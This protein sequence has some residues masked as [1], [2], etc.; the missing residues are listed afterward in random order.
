MGRV[1]RRVLS[2]MSPVFWLIAAGYETA[3]AMIDG[4]EHDY[5]GM[6]VLFSAL[7]IAGTLCGAVDGTDDHDIEVLLDTI[8]RLTRDA[9]LRPVLRKM[10]R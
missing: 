1:V 2:R 6:I 7:G 8:E 5:L 9:D 4:H 3:R 10:P